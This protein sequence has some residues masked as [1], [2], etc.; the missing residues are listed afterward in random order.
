MTHTNLYDETRPLL[1]DQSVEDPKAVQ[2]KPTPIPKVQLGGESWSN[3]SQA[4]C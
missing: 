2:A 3:G 1:S 4:S